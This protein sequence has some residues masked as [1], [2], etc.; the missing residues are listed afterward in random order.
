MNRRATIIRPYGTAYAWGAP[1]L[2][3]INRRAIALGDED[4]N[5]HQTLR[6]DPLFQSITE[7]GME[8]QLP[9]PTT[10]LYL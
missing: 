7:P 4:L 3:A 2:P 6:N 1:V 5:D 10:M 9:L 8:D